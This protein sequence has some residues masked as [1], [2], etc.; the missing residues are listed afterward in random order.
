[1][2][3]RS[4]NILFAIIKEHIRSGAPIGSS[5]LVEKYNLEIS[6]ATVRNIMSE[7]EFDG[8][9]S[10]PHTSAGRIPTEKAY[11]F[12]LEGIKSKRLSTQ[13]AEVFDGILGKKDEL[14]VKKAAKEL[15]RLSGQAVFWAISRHNFYYTGISNLM[16][17][18]E[19]AHLNA[20]SSISE[21]IDHTDD[22]IE[23]IYDS[24]ETGT[25]VFVGSENPFGSICST[26]ITRY[27]NGAVSGLFGILGP[28]RMNYEKNLSLARHINGLMIN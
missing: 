24:I 20:I 11:R 19:F 6:P 16:Q 15:S 9:I 22:I 17:Q 8:F 27:K 23:K 26:I 21:V 4:K 7:L 2:E 1:M 12:Y 14:S 10:Q 25:K 18:P 5:L 3:E 13:E 28:M